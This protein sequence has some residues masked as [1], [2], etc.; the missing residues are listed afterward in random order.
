MSFD[1]DSFL[2]SEA[3]GFNPDDFLGAQGLSEPQVMDEKKDDSFGAD[4]LDVLGELAAG[5]NR[6][7]TEFVDFLGPDTANAILSLAGSEARVP[8]LTESIPGIKGGYMEPGL[9]RD[10][11]SA[12][13][14]AATAATGVAGLLKQSAKSLPAAA[15]QTGIIG[16]AKESSQIALR[17]ASKTGYGTEAALGAVSG[18]GGETGQEIGGDTGALVGSI[19]APASAAATTGA[20]KSLIGKGSEGIK[21][22]MAGTDGMSE[23]AASELIGEAFIREGLSEKE[24][25]E[26]LS[27]LG[28]ESIPAD[29]GESF[30]RLMKAAINEVPRL[31]GVQKNVL[32]SRQTGQS[33]RLVDAF[34]DSTGTPLLDV[35][36]EIVRLNNAFK[37]QIGEAYAR[38]RAVGEEKLFPEP[39]LLPTGIVTPTQKARKAGEV[40]PKRTRLESL[41]ESANVVG[42]TKAAADAELKAK[43]LAGEK[44]TKLDIVDANKRAMDDKIGS[45]IRK[46]E[47]NKARMIIKSKNSILSE[48]DELVPEYK[49]ARSLFAG[50]AE[51]ENAASLGEDF[52]KLKPRDVKDAAES[53][54]ESELKM[55]KL[56]AK[57][58]L[59]DKI[60]NM[61]ITAD[62][63]KRIFG[64]EGSSKKLKSLF[65]SDDQFKAFNDAMEREAAFTITRRIAQ[66]GSSTKMQQADAI[67]AEAAIENGR[68]AMGDPTAWITKLSQI[69][70][71]LLRKKGTKANKDALE[72]AGNILLS[73][74]MDPQKV[75]DIIKKGSASQIEK[76]LKKAA[77]RYQASQSKIIAP[78]VTAAAGYEVQQD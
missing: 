60:N 44:V 77:S 24:V 1:P 76:S 54:G 67:N 75:V 65:K 38:A 14:G 8:T 78:S 7:V 12:T 52:F 26:M 53:M 74:D 30:S 13:G 50:K 20:L 3:S 37:P 17:E 39:D 6:S 56:G 70:G 57:K 21:A 18:A 31:S 32:D 16:G 22:I 34:E 62:S 59:I 42:S 40:K 71:G 29:L 28:D 69:T 41:L 5:A 33:P 58:A 2:G 72:E 35:D 55:F 51:L 66:G 36:D 47:M 61:Q 9:A 45:L 27:K 11:V 46:G 4:T 73:A 25:L 19:L 64:T 63:V 48:V 15:S 68:A 23:K 49:E 10:V 43:R